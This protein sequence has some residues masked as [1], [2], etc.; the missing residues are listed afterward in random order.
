MLVKPLS[1]GPLPA[2]S[3]VGPFSPLGLWLLFYASRPEEEGGESGRALSPTVQSLLYST[4]YV[5]HSTSTHHTHHICHTHHPPPTTHHPPSLTVRYFDF[6]LRNITPSFCSS[7]T[8]TY[9]LHVSPRP[10]LI[11]QPKVR[12]YIMPARL[13]QPRWG[14]QTRWRVSIRRTG[15]WCGHQYRVPIPSQVVHVI[16]RKGGGRGRKGQEGAGRGMCGCN[17]L[18]LV[19]YMH[20]MLPIPRTRWDASIPRHPIMMGNPMPFEHVQYQL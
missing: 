1:D 7:S 19:Q 13:A 5:L 8:E 10:G 4:L 18:V 3:L 20:A 14:D 16:N 6:S 15:T 12:G 17:V 2:E 9:P 11:L